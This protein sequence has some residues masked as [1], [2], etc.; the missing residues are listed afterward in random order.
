MSSD[1]NRRRRS[2]RDASAV[3]RKDDTADD[4]DE[5]VGVEKQQQQRE[6]RNL[7]MEYAALTEQVKVELINSSSSRSTFMPI[8]YE[9]TY[10]MTSYVRNQITTRRLLKRLH[11][12]FHDR[13]KLIIRIKELFPTTTA[14]EVEDVVQERKNQQ[15]ARQ[16]HKNRR[17]QHPLDDRDILLSAASSRLDEVVTTVRR[18]LSTCTLINYETLPHANAG[19]T[20]DELPT[21]KTATLDRIGPQC[22]GC[23]KFFCISRDNDDV[24][25]GEEEDQESQLNKDDPKKHKDLVCRRC[26]RVRYC[27]NDCQTLD[28]NHPRCHLTSY[29]Y[30]DLLRLSMNHI[31]H[32]TFDTKRQLIQQGQDEKLPNRNLNQ[33]MSTMKLPSSVSASASDMSSVEALDIDITNILHQARMELNRIRNICLYMEQEHCIDSPQGNCQV[34]YMN[35]D[36]SDYKWGLDVGVETLCVALNLWENVYTFCSC[37]G[38][39]E[40]ATTTH[41]HSSSETTTEKEA[42]AR[43]KAGNDTD[44]QQ[45]QQQWD[46]ARIIYGSDNYESL[47]RIQDIVEHGSLGIQFTVSLPY[48]QMDTIGSVEGFTTIDCDIPATTPTSTTTEHELPTKCRTHARQICYSQSPFDR[49]DY[50]L[51]MSDEVVDASDDDDDNQ[52]WIRQRNLRNMIGMFGLGLELIAMNPRLMKHTWTDENLNLLKQLQ[53]DARTLRSDL[54]I[55][56]CYYV[57]WFLE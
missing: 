23:G 14:Q 25:E 20:K 3:T 45:Q 43:N 2:R 5:C 22:H 8:Y 34:T 16:Q 46:P 33:T 13:P 32:V 10:L 47:A 19:D 21:T 28:K 55:A 6:S 48:P 11:V 50:A 39:H 41:H 52:N 26:L 29:C 9:Y 7:R 31:R 57:S 1:E 30:P 17:Q 27:S 40:T 44:R 38:A 35:D 37:S 4:D 51:Q 18:R 54:I 42:D 24:D 56:S 49:L 12:L 15:N 53:N 36:E